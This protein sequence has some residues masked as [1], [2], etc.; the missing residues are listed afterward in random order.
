MSV[1]AEEFNFAPFTPLHFRVESCFTRSR[2][3]NGICLSDESC[4]KA[5]SLEGYACGRCE[6]RRPYLGDHCCCKKSCQLKLVLAVLCLVC[7][8]SA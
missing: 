1:Q 3:Y 5:C 7:F 8:F 4:F 6:K 2:R